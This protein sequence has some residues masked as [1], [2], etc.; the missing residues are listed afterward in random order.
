MTTRAKKRATS[1][2]QQ[3]QLDRPKVRLPI[4]DEFLD[5][6]GEPWVVIQNKIPTT[7]DLADILMFTVRNASVKT[8]DDAIRTLDCFQT[9]KAS[10]GTIEMNRDD[11]EW[12]LAHFKETAH[13][14]WKPPDAA[15]LVRWLMSN[16]QSTPT[17]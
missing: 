11:W 17:N 3:K 14:I 8:G 9:I 12:M 16:I 5:I 13:T 10:N 1:K 6:M 15:Y 2:V 7:L 4:P